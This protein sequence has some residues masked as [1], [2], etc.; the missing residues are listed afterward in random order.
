MTVCGACGRENPG[1]ARF[2]LA[3]GAGLLAEPAREVRKTV[4]VLFVD[5]AGSTGL[6]ERL[7]PEP[8]RRLMSRYFDD[9]RAVLER[10]GGTV[11]KFIGDAVVAVFGVPVVHEDDALRAVRAAAELHEVLARLNQE[12]E[13]SLGV[14]L[15][16]RTGVNTG[17]VVTGGSHESF[18]TGDAVNVAAR[19]QQSAGESEILLGATTFALVR[20]AVDAEPAQELELRGREGRVAARR[21]LALRPGAAGVERRHSAE[22]VGRESELRLLADAFER[23]ERT[24]ACHLFTVLGPAGVG[25]SRLAEELISLVGDRARTVRGRCLPYGDGITFWPL[26]EIVRDV[27]G[28]T[29]EESADEARS[30]IAGLLEGDPDADV[31][32]ARIAELVGISGEPGGGDEGFWAARR[33][34]EALAR[35]RPLIVVLDDVNWAEPTFLELIE[36]VSDWVRGAPLLVVCLARPELLDERPGWAGGKLNASSLLLEPLDEREASELIAARLG[37]LDV[38]DAILR[39]VTDVAEGNPLF[40]E[41]MLTMLVGEGLVQRRN[42]AWVSAGDLEGASVPGTIQALLAARI[43]RLDPVE[44]AVLECGAV[45]GKVFHLGAVAALSP[46]SEPGSVLD[47]LVRK[48]LLRP[49][50]AL[51]PGEEAYRFRHILLRDA[52]YDSMPKE[53]RAEL[54][55]RYAT[56]L[57]EKTGE[58]TLEYEEILAYHLESAFRLRAELGRLDGD[59]R[60]LAI[61]AAVRLARAGRRATARDDSTAAATL[62]A[63]AADLLGDDD[64]ARTELLL[65]LARARIELGDLEQADRLIAEAAKRARGLGDARLEHRALVEQQFLRLKTDPAGTTQEVERIAR[66]ALPVFEVAGDQAGLATAWD[67]LAQVHLMACRYAE[68]AAALERALEHARLAG[69]EREAEIV[70]GLETAH[71]WGPTP[72]EESIARCEARLGEALGRRPTVE[73]ALLGTLAGLEAMRGQFDEARALYRRQ[74]AIHEDLGRPYSAAAWTMVYAR[75]EM[76]AGDPAAAEAELRH[77]YET[78]ERMGELGV[79]STLS[80]YLA[81]AL[82][83]QYRLEEAD[84]YT[85]ISEE[86]ATLDDIASQ[87]W[88]RLTRARLLGHSGESAA[89]ALA[90]EA[91]ALAEPTDDL[92][93]KARS[94]IDLAEAL[95]LLEDWDEV[96]SLLEQAARLAEAKGDVVTATQTRGE[97]AR[98]ASAATEI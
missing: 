25:K 80:A 70:I 65:P 24:R 57:A 61:A 36:Y 41:E 39:R 98:I 59:S 47:A 93:L 77:G 27:A 19:L 72:V 10:H 21:L 50:R 86:A 16:I 94:L 11:E 67:L 15:A 45:E 60:E 55:E 71:Y 84:R 38:D 96:P 46:G 81:D 51:L 48:E 4:T 26:G 73:A 8:L 58:R 91:V 85:R 5:L 2:C 9:V 31:V 88:W 23:A 22:F 87:V 42:G 64:P 33:F 75:V 17:E 74:R 68:R 89:E 79:L 82:Y 1:E 20:D 66:L 78:L 69:G 28:L 32:A 30:R 7:D 62:L 6:G 18:A 37:R 76:L 53:T 54:H 92:F 83:A 40:M 95:R 3:C 14:T 49:D 52:A 12:L 44:R 56:W 90:R 97:L 34:V 13:A 63:R 29:G 35:V 43:D